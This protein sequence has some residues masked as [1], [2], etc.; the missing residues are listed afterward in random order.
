MQSQLVKHRKI[1]ERQGNAKKKQTAVPFFNENLNSALWPIT[2]VSVCVEA[3]I[4]HYHQRDRDL[5]RTIWHRH[6]HHHYIKIS[7]RHYTYRQLF[8]HI[9]KSKKLFRPHIF[10]VHAFNLFFFFSSL[11]NH[12]DTWNHEK[13]SSEFGQSFYIWIKKKE[14]KKILLKSFL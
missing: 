14:K 4:H 5:W 8:S 10:S 9:K 12:T 3:Q 6:R 11:N 2:K 7:F 1:K 13:R